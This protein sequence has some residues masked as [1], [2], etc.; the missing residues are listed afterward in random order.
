MG[1]HVIIDMG[2]GDV[3]DDVIVAVIAATGAGGHG[4]GRCHCRQAIWGTM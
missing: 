4:G 1:G 2:L 3:G